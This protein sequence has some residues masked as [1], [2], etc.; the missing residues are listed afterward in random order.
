MGLM[1]PSRVV[2]GPVCPQRWAGRAISWGARAW[3]MVKA[4]MLL[5]EVAQ[6]ASGLDSGCGRATV[7][8][9]MGTP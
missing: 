4:G 8:S 3:K 2:G 7:V 5:V 1:S 9:P 6:E